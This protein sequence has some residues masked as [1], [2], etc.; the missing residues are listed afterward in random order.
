[1]FWSLWDL[2]H[3]YEQLQ[4][5]RS[6]VHIFCLSYIFVAYFILFQLFPQFI[7]CWLVLFA[8]F[9]NFLLYFIRAWILLKPINVCYICNKHW[10]SFFIYKF[11]TCY[12]LISNTFT[13]WLEADDFCWL[14]CLLS[15]YIYSRTW[16]RLYVF[17][18]C[19][20]YSIFWEEL[21]GGKA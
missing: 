19:Y 10:S 4:I 7:L 21:W 18:S 13:F 8:W 3:F 17:G 9:Y 6:T 5:C 1:M 16:C 15:D 11:Y 20:L 14:C 2:T 12:M